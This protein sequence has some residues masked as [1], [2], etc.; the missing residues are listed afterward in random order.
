[1]PKVESHGF[2]CSKMLRPD[3]RAQRSGDTFGKLAEVAEHRRSVKSLELGAPDQIDPLPLRDNDV[4]VHHSGPE[5]EDI[6]GVR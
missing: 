5:K 3:A 2:S 4:A 6:G 1:V